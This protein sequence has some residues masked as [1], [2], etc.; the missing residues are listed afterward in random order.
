MTNYIPLDLSADLSPKTHATV[1]R[2][3]GDFGLD[4]TN[5]IEAAWLVELMACIPDR[6][7][8]FPTG[9]YN[10]IFTLK[11]IIAQAATKVVRIYVTDGRP[12]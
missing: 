10:T 1:L 5:A 9:K 2:I 7:Y 3:A 4:P 8:N 11:H 12:T 6:T